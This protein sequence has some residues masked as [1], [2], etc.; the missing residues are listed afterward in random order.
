MTSGGQRDLALNKQQ[1]LAFAKQQTS[2]ASMQRPQGNQVKPRGSATTPTTRPLFATNLGILYVPIR[3]PDGTL[4][5]RLI[6]APVQGSPASA[7]PLDAG[8]IIKALDGQPIRNLDD[9]L[10]HSDRTTVDFIDSGTNTLQKGNIDL[11]SQNR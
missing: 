8:D 2:I 7:L 11:P 5:L 1:A 10:R 6:S 4:G 3:F 9:V